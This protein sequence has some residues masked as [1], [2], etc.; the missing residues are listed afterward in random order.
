MDNNWVGECDFKYI[1][2][3][4]FSTST[5]VL[6]LLTQ[7]Q[8]APSEQ[9]LTS[10]TFTT[11]RSRRLTRK[12]LTPTVPLPSPELTD[13]ISHPSSPW[14]MNKVV[15]RCQEWCSR[16]G[17]HM[18]GNKCSQQCPL[19]TFVYPQPFSL[20]AVTGQ[21]TD[22]HHQHLPQR[23]SQGF[24]LGFRSLLASVAALIILHYS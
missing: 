17:F 4:G 7:L 2:Q 10:V 23:L 21:G 19:E 20:C 1:S 24:T 13:Q 14:V 22:T 3:V 5:P 6:N 9:K 16:G 18:E 15:V 8:E 12:Q 11:R